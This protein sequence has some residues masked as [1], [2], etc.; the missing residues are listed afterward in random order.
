MRLNLRR[1]FRLLRGTRPADPVATSP[2]TALPDGDA[3]ATGLNERA[4]RAATGGWLAR[5]S[6][7]EQLARLASG[8]DRGREDLLSFLRIATPQEWVGVDEAVRESGYAPQ[9]SL[10]K[11]VGNDLLGVGLATMD[12]SG[13]RRETAVRRITDLEDPL[14]G[15]FLALRT[16]DW[17]EPVAELSRSALIDRVRTDLETAAFAAPL[18]FALESRIRAATTTDAILD[19]VAADPQLQRRLLTSTDVRTRRRALELAL[20]GGALASEELVSLAL[21]DP[22]T[23]VATSAGGAAVARARQAGD[24]D[25]LARLLGGRAAVRRAVLEDLAPGPEAVELAESHLFDRSPLVRGAAQS[26]V[27]RAGGDP[28]SAY[29]RSFEASVRVAISV[30][31]LGYVGGPGDMPTIVNALGSPDAAVRRAAVH[32]ASRRAGPELPS[33]LIPLLDDPSPGVVRAAERRLRPFVK[34]I[35]RSVIDGLLASPEPHVRR[36]V[37]RLLRRRSP[38]E[39]LEANF[40]GLA[41]P[42]E[43]LRQDAEIDLLSWLH[44]GAASAPRADLETRLGLDL[45]LTR[46]EGGLGRGIVDRIRFHAGLRP[47]DLKLT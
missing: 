36:A 28:A 2:G 15:A 33:L 42:E 4:R 5:M 41:D 26:V 18:L 30:F 20:V 13:Y 14:V 47:Q 39:R 12:A 17:V 7:Q 23:V 38:H 32:A 27:R 43:R 24:P 31:E 29:R 35:D 3:F 6:L 8:D 9:R 21:H 45:A 37:F 22:D 44:R 19:A 1:A 16:V 11:D 10:L 40:K 25:A 34:S 46:V